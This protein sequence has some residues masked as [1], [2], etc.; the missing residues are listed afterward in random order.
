MHSHNNKLS[1]SL[2]AF[3]QDCKLPYQDLLTLRNTKH[4]L[5]FKFIWYWYILYV[6]LS[7]WGE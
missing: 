6:L 5:Y 1:F 4:K 2:Q 7:S 3:S